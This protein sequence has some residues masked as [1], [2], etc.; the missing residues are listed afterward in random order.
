MIQLVFPHLTNYH[1][2]APPVENNQHIH[3]VRHPTVTCVHTEIWETLFWFSI[4]STG[5]NTIQFRYSGSWLDWLV[6][7]LRTYMSKE[8]FWFFYMK[9]FQNIAKERYP[10]AHL[11]NITDCL[12]C[13]KYVKNLGTNRK[14]PVHIFKFLITFGL[15]WFLKVTRE[16]D[17]YTKQYEKC[18]IGQEPNTWPHLG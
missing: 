3:C 12:L 10:L 13:T 1:T 14:G 15:V 17:K 6:L 18:V 11:E 7:A 2:R 5:L 4:F 16:R 9:W 8:R